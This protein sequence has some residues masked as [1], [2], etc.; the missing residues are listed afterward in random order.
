MNELEIQAEM[1]ALRH[2]VR[3]LEMMNQALIDAGKKVV[4]ERDRLRLILN[5]TPGAVTPEEAPPTRRAE[6]S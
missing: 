4:A 6:E 2:E 1:Q 5:G 3:A